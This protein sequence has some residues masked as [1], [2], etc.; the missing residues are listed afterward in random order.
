MKR[1]NFLTVFAAI[2][3]LCSCQKV[4]DIDVKNQAPTVMIEGF[5][6]DDSSALATVKIT[7]T[8]NFSETGDF[9]TVA[10]AEVTIKD[11]A[12]N[13]YTLTETSPGIYQ[14]ASLVGVSGRTYYL[15]INAEGKTYTANST[16][17]QKVNLDAI[18][19]DEG[20]GPGPPGAMAAT[21]LYTDPAGKGNSYRFK[22]RKNQVES[23]SI[24]LLD[25]QIIDGGQNTRSLTDQEID[26]KSGDTAVVTMMCID[27]P[28]Q[29]YF[30]SLSQNG[31][32]P[33]ASATPANPVSNITGATLGYFSAHTI[34]IKTAIV[35]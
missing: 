1:L 25:D 28:V 13:S 8:L 3:L 10:G 14:N 22:L 19:I 21:P 33:D 18:K 32:G 30:Y 24:L 7:K 26:F 11:N 4:I 35:P 31:N 17:P 5:V 23:K 27:K 20:F 15:T 6:T 2:G 9:P 16:L 29:L 12:G 34:Q